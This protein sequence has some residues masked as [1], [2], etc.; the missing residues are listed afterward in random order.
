[1]VRPALRSR[2]LR[3]LKKKTPSGRSK[4]DY[5]RR[6]PSSSLCG[7]CGKKL[8]GVPRDLPSKYKNLSSTKKKPNRKFGGNLCSPCSR[9]VIKQQVLNQLFKKSAE[10]PNF[11]S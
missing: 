11:K 9:S 1:M 6:K 3:R 7:S 4:V 5:V 2:S 10:P 8:H